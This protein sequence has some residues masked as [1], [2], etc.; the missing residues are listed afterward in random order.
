MRAR[1]LELLVA[2]DLGEA[3]QIHGPRDAA[4][5]LPNTLSI[6]V[7]GLEARTVLEMVS[8]LSSVHGSIPAALI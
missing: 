7:P 6:G 4:L 3:M 1:L 2:G 5:R 8:I